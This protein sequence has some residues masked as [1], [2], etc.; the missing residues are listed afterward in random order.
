MSRFAR[1]YEDP[2]YDDL[3][4]YDEDGNIADEDYEPTPF[5]D[6]SESAQQRLM[7]DVVAG[8]QQQEEF[9]PFNTS[10]S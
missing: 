10:N 2:S 9:N 3:Y 1:I 4:I 5:K 7:S 8:K 6:W